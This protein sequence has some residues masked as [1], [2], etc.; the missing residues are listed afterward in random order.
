MS[1]S[2]SPGRSREESIEIAPVFGGEPETLSRRQGE[3]VSDLGP[4]DAGARSRNE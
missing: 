1:H 2:S 4:V 3:E